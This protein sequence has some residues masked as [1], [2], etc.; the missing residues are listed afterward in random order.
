MLAR[1]IYPTMYVNKRPTYLSL[2]VTY[3]A[4]VLMADT[5]HMRVHLAFTF[6]FHT[7]EASLSSIFGTSF[8]LKHVC[9]P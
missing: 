7:R 4:V 1:C 8:L 3:A 2:N 9:S 5:D 6:C